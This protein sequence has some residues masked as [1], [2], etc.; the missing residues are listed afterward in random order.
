MTS[1]LNHLAGMALGVKPAGAARLSL[2][3]RFSQPSFAIGPGSQGLEPVE[4]T[5]RSPSAQTIATPAPAGPRDRRAPDDEAARVQNPMAHRDRRGD[6][7]P[8]RPVGQE[9]SQ[10]VQALA[11]KT[12]PNLQDV[13]LPPRPLARP[14]DTVRSATG[15][16][17]PVVDQPSAQLPPDPP[18]SSRLAS[19]PA[20]V[21]PV[22]AAPLSQAIVSARAATHEERP[23]IHV[24]ID[25]IEVRS[26][27]SPK[28]A[29][30]QRRAR[31][32]PS[33][34]LSDYLRE[35]GGRG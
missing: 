22:P 1:F 25:R 24:T 33:V 15:V 8:E 30:E 16:S 13:A 19:E 21:R 9:F 29:A 14:A 4:E 23:V 20:H 34:S 3:S 12:V 18:T 17:L 11:P 6:G 10:P 32:Q 28:P 2:P 35:S 27:A 5:V 7:P 26:P 31:P